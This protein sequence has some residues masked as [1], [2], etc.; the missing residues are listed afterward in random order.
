M[1]RM[2]SWTLHLYL[3]LQ[4]D[5]FVVVVDKLFFLDFLCGFVAVAVGFLEQFAE[6]LQ[7]GAK[8]I[9]QYYKYTIPLHVK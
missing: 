7:A 6:K 8:T 4:A 1:I 5:I 3:V 2:R 9:H